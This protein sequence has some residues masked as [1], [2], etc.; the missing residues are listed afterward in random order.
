MP[1]D[2]VQQRQTVHR[3]IFS[4]VGHHRIQQMPPVAHPP[5]QCRMLEQRRGFHS[6]KS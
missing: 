4:A 1:F 2:L 3:K 6:I 5:L